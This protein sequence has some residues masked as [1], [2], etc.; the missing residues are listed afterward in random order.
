MFKLE[1]RC[2][3]QL[4]E[5]LDR[6]PAVLL[7]GARQTGKTD[8]ARKVAAGRPSV[9]FDLED[10]DDL[11]A[12][13][14]PGVELRQHPGKLIVI[15]EVHHKPDLFNVIRVIIDELRAQGSANGKFLLLGSV[16]E[17][18][19]RQ[20]EGLT[21]RV[22]DMRLHP[23]N[24]LDVL[25]DGSLPTASRHLPERFAPAANMEERM[26]ELLRQRGGYPESLL[27]DSEQSLHW[28]RSYLLA[29]IR[30]DAI[31]PRV[32]EGRFMA[33]LELIASKQGSV[34]LKQEFARQLGFGKKDT[35]TL[36]AMFTTLEQMMLI[37]RLPAYTGGDIKQQVR[38]S[39][40]YYICD[41]GIHQC[42]VN[43]ETPGLSERMKSAN[44]E[45]F[46]IENIMSVLPE[47]WRGFYFGLAKGPEADLVV[48]RPGGAIWVIE[49]KSGRDPQPGSLSRVA[50]LLKPERSFLVHGGSFKHRGSGNTSI[51]SLHDIMHELQ[52]HACIRQQPRPQQAGPLP[53]PE[54]QALMQ[55]LER[56]D[57]M[58][59]VRRDEFAS[60]VIAAAGRCCRQAEGP[61]DRQARS[62]WVQVRN[63]L[64]AWLRL[65]SRMQ[66][67]A[68]AADRWQQALCSILE[69]IAELPSPSAYPSSQGPAYRFSGE[70]AR[71][72][73]YD[74]FV[75]VIAMLVENGCHRFVHTLLARRYRVRGSMLAFICFWS[76]AP[77][78]ISV[79]TPEEIA[80]WT[81][82]TA[83]D[84]EQTVGEFVS[85][86]AGISI[87]S[88]LAAELLMF[89]FGM[90][91][92]ERLLA[93]EREMAR[94][95]K[96]YF[97]WDP[98][99]LESMSV[100][101]PLAFFQQAENRRGMEHLL[102]CLGIAPTAANVRRLREVVDKYLEVKSAFSAKDREDF[103]G[104]LNVS[105]WH[106]LDAGA[107]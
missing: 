34:T 6:S 106:S 65:E 66:P 60:H 81:P 83:A 55:A 10:P 31:R 91:L 13:E 70:F 53:S 21:G 103:I 63:Q 86:Q 20:S 97:C 94:A 49:I 44:W 40:K 54:C 98:W 27:A 41:S 100:V 39:G 3:R 101:P 57:R 7:V 50:G 61:S 47:G 69:A 56:D 95:K 11:R 73:C 68:D 62:A 85:S 92:C 105:N 22:M 23:F 99:L 51:L 18:L 80:Y 9:R 35:A 5:M 42:L 17:D 74:L 37:R 16:I 33:L 15:D 82:P 48:E 12:L 75:H 19:Q 77:K 32:P 107:D 1:R 43:R 96:G 58:L 14:N 36:N 79:R 84:R 46:A 2:E 29:S 88:L 76:G 90:T 30:K 38:K 8:L 71:L 104:F 25:A 93:E 24:L 45:G 89:V 28:R 78:D 64:L 87:E 72:C 59:N 102:S 26:V 52:A 4:I 67:E